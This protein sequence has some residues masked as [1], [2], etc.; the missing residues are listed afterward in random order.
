MKVAVAPAWT[1]PPSGVFATVTSGQRTVTWPGS[2][3]VPSL[4]EVI[5]PVLL[6]SAQ[7]ALVVALVSVT[8]PLTGAAFGKFGLPAI[9]PMLQVRTSAALRVQVEPVPVNPL[10][11]QLMPAAGRQRVADDD[12]RGAAFALVRPAQREA[13]VG[14]GGDG[15]AVRRLDDLD[16]G[17]DDPEALGRQVRVFAS[18]V[19]GALGGRVLDAEAVA[20][21]LLS[22]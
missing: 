2:V 3:S 7:L 20:T 8:V 4:I 14:A 21:H 11:D 10:M 6:I 19:L 9:V 17:R 18:E 5:W 12:A 1:V 13:D 22:G 16:V 15:A